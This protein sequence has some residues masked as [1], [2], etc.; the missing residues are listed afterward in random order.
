MRKCAQIDKH[1]DPSTCSCSEK[2]DQCEEIYGKCPD[3]GEF[4]S[5]KCDCPEK[6]CDGEDKCQKANIHTKSPAADCACVCD[7]EL[8]GIPA[9]GAGKSWDHDTC[10][11]IEASKCG[12][13]ADV[14]TSDK[15]TCEAYCKCNG[16][17]VGNCWWSSPDKKCL[18]GANYDGLPI[19]Q[20]ALPEPGT[21]IE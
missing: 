10:T 7:E 5:T 21:P 14:V 3:G 17:K 15:E 20:A 9:C 1:A 19:D 8:K 4:Q 2:D 18:Y 16:W 12:N 11:C 6:T 13:P